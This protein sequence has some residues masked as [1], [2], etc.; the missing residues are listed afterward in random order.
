MTC[1]PRPLR[2]KKT[3]KRATRS[4]PIGEA[5]LKAIPIPVVG[6]RPPPPSATSTP[7]DRISEQIIDTA[8]GDVQGDN[9]T[10]TSVDTSCQEYLLDDSINKTDPITGEVAS[11]PQHMQLLEATTVLPKNTQQAVDVGGNISPESTKDYFSSVDDLQS[12]NWDDDTLTDKKLN[13]VDDN[14]SS[15]PST[16]APYNTRG[17]QKKNTGAKTKSDTGRKSSGTTSSGDD[18][19]S[20]A[21]ISTVKKRNTN[22]HT[23]P[24]RIMQLEKDV[25]I[26]KKALET[27]A[28]KT[29]KESQRNEKRIELLQEK[30]VQQ[31]QRYIE[32]MERMDV[33]AASI[34]RLDDI[35]QEHSADI[36]E[37]SNDN[38]TFKNF[39]RCS[40][41]RQEQWGEKNG[42]FGED[43]EEGN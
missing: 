6:R 30:A 15:R 24:L 14:E 23:A 5:M 21:Y 20:D 16:P 40:E 19:G 26:L 35:V 13:K 18:S 12:R 39:Q 25:A 3:E 11:Q 31:M 41:A 29:D 10:Q 7:I 38:V 43:G 42:R 28:E 33:I 9:I 32:Q 27:M 8:G 1:C 2:T 4:H 36:T 37:L 17:K 34:V 22:S